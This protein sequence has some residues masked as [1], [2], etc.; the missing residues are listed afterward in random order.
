MGSADVA[1]AVH[2]NF[3]QKH[4]KNHG[5]MLNAGTVIKTNSNQVT[6][7]HTKHTSTWTCIFS[8]W[9]IAISARF[10]LCAYSLSLAL[11]RSLSLALFSPALSLSRARALS[12]SARVRMFACVLHGTSATPRRPRRDLW[13]ESFRETPQYCRHR[14]LSFAMIARAAQLLARP[15]PRSL[16]SEQ[17]TWVFRVGRC[18]VFVRR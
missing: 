12:L 17:S 18:T 5:P 11:S 16:G 14:S 10:R 7:A 4:E 1:H 9:W 8:P 15:S 6:H 3:A 2:P 13:C